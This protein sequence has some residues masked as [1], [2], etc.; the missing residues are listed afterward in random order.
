MSPQISRT[1]AR[2]PPPRVIVSYWLNG[3]VQVK[4]CP[5]TLVIR[6]KAQIQSAAP[7]TVK[8]IPLGRAGRRPTMTTAKSTPTRIANSGAPIDPSIAILSF[9]LFAGIG[10][11][12]HNMVRTGFQRRPALRVAARVD[13]PGRSSC[14]SGRSM[15]DSQCAQVAHGLQSND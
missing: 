2:P 9:R 10:S 6:V 14:V 13:A 3:G 4:N 11:E 5:A 8:P 12:A 1:A 7:R 15:C